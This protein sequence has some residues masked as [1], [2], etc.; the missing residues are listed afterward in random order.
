MKFQ[1]SFI[2]LWLNFVGVS[3]VTGNQIHRPTEHELYMRQF[4]VQKVFEL[5][6][7]GIFRSDKCGV[8]S[9]TAGHLSNGNEFPRS[10]EVVIIL[11]C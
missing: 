2:Y 4:T 8:I 7:S 9:R 11:H 1:G 10:T 6:Q 3:C 5:G